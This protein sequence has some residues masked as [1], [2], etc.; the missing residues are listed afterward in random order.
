MP[1]MPSISSIGSGFGFALTFSA[2]SEVLMCSR[3]PN[4]TSTSVQSVSQHCADPHPTAYTMV[5]GTATV[6]VML[7]MGSCL[8]QC[9]L[10]P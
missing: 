4:I 8:H 3:H 10:M 1:S 5:H 6:L 9:L 2:A 7:Q